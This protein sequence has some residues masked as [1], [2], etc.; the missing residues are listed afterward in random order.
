MSGVFGI[1]A[2]GVLLH[3]TSLPGGPIG[4]LGPAAH[5][6]VDWLADAGQA[7][8]QILPLVA[9][10]EGGSPYNGLSAVAGNPFLV[11]LDALVQDCLLEEGDVASELAGEPLHFGRVSRWKGERLRLAH[12][13]LDEGANPGLAAE[14][15]VYR[16]ANAGWLA[17]YALFRAIRDAHQG[18]LWTE[19]EPELRDR[20]PAAMRRATRDLA[21]EIEFREFEQFLFDRQWGALRAYAHS[22]G[23]RVIG[24]IPIFVA[25]DSADVWAHRQL[26]ELDHAGRPLVVAGVPP[27][28]FSDTGQRWGNPLFRWDTAAERIYEWWAERFRRTLSWVDVV[29]VDHFRGFESYW[30]IPA[31]EETAVHGRWR[32]GPGAD[33]FKALHRQLG[34]IPIVAEDLGLIT[35]EVEALRAELD[36]PGMRVVQFG[37]DGVPANPHLPENYPRQSV[38][39][40]GTHD[41]DTLAGWWGKASKEERGEVWRRIGRRCADP[42]WLLVELVLGS[43][44]DLAIVPVQDVLGMGSEARMNTPGTTSANWTW[45]LGPDELTP[46]AGR[47]LRRATQRSGR[48]VRGAAVVGAA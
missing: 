12:R 14:L 21:E 39:Y 45:R 15:K 6:F 40:T 2:S 36:L 7:Y 20:E 35:R 30:E 46:D 4:D 31:T 3:P 38:V 23:V 22:R 26:F 13:N 11:S 41:N 43:L 32:K 10:D 16:A 47:R 8:W 29:R 9:V 34:P 48:L 5:Q 37:F 33:L 18:A 19:W 42:H 44:A 17:D 28:Y 24:D 25:H 27:D 1:R